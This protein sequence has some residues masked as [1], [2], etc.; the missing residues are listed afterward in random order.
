MDE[1]P[2]D[3]F[4]FPAHL[5]ELVAM[6]ELKAA[7]PNDAHRIKIVEQK[8]DKHER[9][10][11]LSDWAKNKRV[12]VESSEAGEKFITEHCNF[13]DQFDDLVD[14]SSVATHHF[15]LQKHLRALIGY[16]KDE[17]Q[18]RAAIEREQ[19]WREMAIMKGRVGDA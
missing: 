18:Q 16:T 12:F 19:K 4:C 17:M 6:Q 2:D 8:G 14:M 9:A 10:T 15:G 1:Y 7:R 11:V 5:L 13:P 3:D